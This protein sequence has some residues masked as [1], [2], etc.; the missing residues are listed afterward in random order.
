M[1]FKDKSLSP[2]SEIPILDMTPMINGEDIHELAVEL[3]LACKKMGF[4][5]ALNHGVPESVIAN[6]FAASRRFFE[7]SVE[8]RMKVHKDRFH[9]GYLPLGTTKYPGKA[10][11]LKDSFDTLYEEGKDKPK[12]MSVGLHCRII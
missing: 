6:A 3:K 1:T 5:Y 7:Q 9:R 11:D 12:M 8:W 4:F 10:A 2:S